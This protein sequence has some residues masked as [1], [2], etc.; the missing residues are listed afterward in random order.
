M[1]ADV[2]Q[3]RLAHASELR[4]KLRDFYEDY[5]QHLDDG[6]L[7]GWINYFIEDCHYRVISRENYTLN[8]PI[9]LIYCMNKNMVRDRVMAM[10]ETTVCQPRTIRH[11]ISGVR[12][13][14]VKDDEIHAQANFMISECLVDS[15]PEITLTG[16]YQDI[17]VPTDAG[18]LFKSRDCIIDNYRVKTS[19]IIPV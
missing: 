15:E 14:A 12:V 19:L 10:R 6:D 8:L 3:K 11:F 5:A 18:Y 9:G 4:W 2:T 16:Q 17:I 7:E 13:K 1:T